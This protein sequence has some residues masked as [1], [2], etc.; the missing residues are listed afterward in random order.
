MKEYWDLVKSTVVNYVET[1]LESERI[2]DKGKIIFIGLVV[3]LLFFKVI[4]FIIT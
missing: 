3:F 2:F 4:H 1:N